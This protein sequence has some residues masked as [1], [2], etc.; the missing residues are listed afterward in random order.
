MRECGECTLCC[1]VTRVPELD[2]AEMVTCHHCVNGC[3]IYGA[4]PESCRTFQC[5][6]LRG[7]LGK[8][9]RPDKINIVMEKLPGVPVVLALLE[10][11]YSHGDIPWAVTDHYLSAGIS[12]VASNGMTQKPAGVSMASVRG[13]IHKAARDLG[14]IQ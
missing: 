10:P 13:D 7:E 14:V 8:W 5:E 2:K 1:T 12:M 4:R 3:T 9:M 6:W 11:G